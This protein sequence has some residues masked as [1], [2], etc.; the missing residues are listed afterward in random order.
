MAAAQ[1]RDAEATRA[2]I[3]EAAERLFVERGFG[4]AAMAELAEAAGVTKSLIHH[5][6]GSKQELWDNVKLYRFREYAR[7]QR[8]LLEQGPASLEMLVN[9]VEAY[10]RFLQTHPQMLRMMAWVH[11]EQDKHCIS[12]VSALVDE[13]AARIAE[14]QANGSIRANLDPRHI[15]AS[16]VGMTTHWFD[17]RHEYCQPSDDD[18]DHQQADEAFLQSMKSI[19]VEGISPRS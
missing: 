4:R 7:R 9:S 5:H 1:K 8:E 11:L 3:L 19:F 18:P 13:G 2:T 12:E 17:H 15:V 16:F 14:G 10:F 6:F